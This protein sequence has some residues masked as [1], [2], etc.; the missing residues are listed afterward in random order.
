MWIWASFLTDSIQ[1][2]KKTYVLTIQ[3]DLHSIFIFLLH[4]FMLPLH[5]I[6]Q[7]ASTG[8]S[9][10][11]PSSTFCITLNSSQFSPHRIPIF[12]LQSSR[13]NHETITINKQQRHIS[14]REFKK[15]GLN[16]SR[17]R[18][19]IQ[20]LEVVGDSPHQESDPVSCSFTSCLIYRR[21]Y[22]STTA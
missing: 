4:I 11:A 21:D 15:H 3:E 20:Y 18:G 13:N 1:N 6:V 16:R 19:G 2:S 14:N 12:A 8:F 7:S 22:V 17:R 10:F 9:S 5:F